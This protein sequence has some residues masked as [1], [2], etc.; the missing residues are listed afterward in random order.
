MRSPQTSVFCWRAIERMQRIHRL[1][2]N[3][4]YPNSTKLAREFEIRSSQTAAGMLVP[5][6]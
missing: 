3:R 2:E 4:E 5:H 1:M 6:S